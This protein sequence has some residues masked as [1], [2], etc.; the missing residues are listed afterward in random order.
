MIP[1]YYQ[2]TDEEEKWNTCLKFKKQLN[3]FDIIATIHKKHPTKKNI[4]NKYF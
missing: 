3:T 1:S 2:V 4:G